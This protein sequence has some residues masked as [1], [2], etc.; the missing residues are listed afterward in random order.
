MIA[1]TI[2]SLPLA[3]LATHPVNLQALSD[4]EQT[5]WTK[6]GF[7]FLTGALVEWTAYDDSYPCLNDASSMLQDLYMMYYIR[8]NSDPDL[9]DLNWQIEIAPYLINFLQTLEASTCK[10]KFIDLYNQAEENLPED[11][12]PS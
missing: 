4:S 10:D 8:E 3:A 12:L 6:F 5:K 9:N 1:K 7:G 11:T 2:L